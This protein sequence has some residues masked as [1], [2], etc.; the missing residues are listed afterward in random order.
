MRTDGIEP[1][2]PAVSGGEH[3]LAH[4]FEVGPIAG[5]AGG[6]AAVSWSEMQA[7]Q[8]QTG[9]DLQPWE[10]RT[11]R[12]LSADFANECRRAEAHDAVSPM[13]IVSTERNRAAVA[14]KIGMEFGAMAAATRARTR[15]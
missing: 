9:L 2:L 1:P 10:V 15:Q 6:I 13:T 4:L 3:L 5:G 14:R 11:L 7:W 12:R 8:R